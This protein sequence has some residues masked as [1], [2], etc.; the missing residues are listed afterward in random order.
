MKK[1]DTPIYFRWIALI[2]CSALFLNACATIKKPYG[3]MGKEKYS[4]IIQILLSRSTPELSVVIDDIILVDA[5]RWGTRRVDVL[6]VPPGEHE[7]KVFASSWM[8]SKPFNYSKTI[9][10]LEDG[11]T[12][13]IIQVPPYSKLYWTYIIITLVVTS[14]ASIISTVYLANSGSYVY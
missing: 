4:G 2:L 3:K 7:I 8:L 9:E 14:A 13:V 6:R 5:R 12:P 1:K 11:S 10:V